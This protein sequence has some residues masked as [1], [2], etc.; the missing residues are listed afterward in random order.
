MSHQRAVDFAY[1]TRPD[2]RTHFL[3]G[4]KIRVD[5]RL[6]TITA[7][8]ND[9]LAHKHTL[10]YDVAPLTGVS[11]LRSV[12]LVDASGASVRPLCF[13]WVDGDGAVY[14]PLKNLATLDIGTS[15]IQVFP[16]D[17]NASGRSDLV[18]ASS[19]YDSSS[20]SNKL[21]LDVYLSNADGSISTTPATGSGSTGLLFPDQL[22]PLEANGDGRTDL[23]C[24]SIPSLSPFSYE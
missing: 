8:I 1:E 4:Y 18:V 15:S 2:Q 10:N 11:R 23:V 6:S 16:I 5:R 19:R 9:A 7:S 14:E 13:D 21:H 3:G 17:A 20:K 24:L 22:L 12:A